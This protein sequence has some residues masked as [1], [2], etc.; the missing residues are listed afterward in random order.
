M[1]PSP[2]S[3]VATALWVGA[4]LLFRFYVQRFHVLNPAYGAI[5]VIM[6][7]L[8]WMYYS[9]FVLLAAGELNSELQ[10][11]TSDE[12]HRA[13]SS[14]SATKAMHDA[15]Q[16]RDDVRSVA[17]RSRPRDPLRPARVH[18]W[19]AVALALGTGI[20][21]GR[22]RHNDSTRARSARPRGLRSDRPIGRACGAPFASCELTNNR[23]DR[24]IVE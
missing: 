21:L 20:M 14:T 5:G 24:R 17:L 8:S 10:R 11:V 23:R 6:V 9:S 1:A 2:G 16:M 12:A 19:R 7:L 4:T 13:L 3:T 15:K 18:P 22:S